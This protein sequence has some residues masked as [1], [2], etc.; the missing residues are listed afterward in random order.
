MHDAEP[1]D[2]GERVGDL[3]R[4]LDGFVD[5]VRRSGAGPFGHPVSKAAAVGVV[6]DEV[7]TA[8]RELVD[9]VHTDGTVGVEAPQ[10]PCLV[11]E[12][13]ADVVVVGPVLG[14]DLDRDLRVEPRVAASQTVANAPL[15]ST[16][17]V[18]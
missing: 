1:V 9:E 5:R 8:I 6:H 16:R 14:E 11:G 3:D 15:P 7:G 17:S 12:A 4:D 10:N 18:S 13:L 2:H